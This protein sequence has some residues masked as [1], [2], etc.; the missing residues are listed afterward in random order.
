[1][2]QSRMHVSGLIFTGRKNA[3]FMAYPRVDC[4]PTASLSFSLSIP[5]SPCL[6]T[7]FCFSVCLSVVCAVCVVCVHV[8]VG[9]GARVSAMSTFYWGKGFNL[10]CSSIF[11]PV[12]QS[13]IEQLFAR[14]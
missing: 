5:H 4:I 3:V 9:V 2:V 8:Y 13:S 6:S 7:C 11:P 10:S 14:R 12:L 1:M